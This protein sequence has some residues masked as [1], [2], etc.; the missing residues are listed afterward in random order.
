MPPLAQHGLRQPRSPGSDSGRRR[1]G[2]GHGGRPRRPRPSQPCGS[3][4]HRRPHDPRSDTADA[5]THGDWTPTLDTG[6]RTPGRSDARTGHWTSVAWTGTRGHWT[7]A[8]D[9]GRSHRTLGV[10]PLGVVTRRCGCRPCLRHRVRV[11]GQR[12]AL[13]RPTVF[14]WTAP[15]ALDSPGRLG[16]E[17]TCQRTRYL[18]QNRAAARSLRYPTAPRR[19]AVLGRFQVERRAAGRLPSGIRQRVGGCL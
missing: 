13:G 3:L 1:A 16:S 18:P 19:I 2:R 7:L 14:L 11:L 6:R 4:P 5:G 17:A 8:P 10:R 15:A 9:T 12:P